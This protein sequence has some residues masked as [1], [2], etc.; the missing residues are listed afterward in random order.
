MEQRPPS[1]DQNNN[2]S[3]SCSSP[4]GKTKQKLDHTTRKTSCTKIMLVKTATWI[5]NA[6]RT[7]LGAY[8]LTIELIAVLSHVLIVLLISPLYVIYRPAF[9]Y[10]ELVG[11]DW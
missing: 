3:S 6:Y 9:H 1:P 5:N 8:L 11:Y 4:T 10:I 7:F 2:T